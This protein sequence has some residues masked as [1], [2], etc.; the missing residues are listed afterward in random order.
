MY[1]EGLILVV[2]MLAVYHVLLLQ[3]QWHTQSLVILTFC[4][5]AIYG[6]RFYLVIILVASCVLAPLLGRSRPEEGQDTLGTGVR[7]IVIV[8]CFIL[9]LFVLGLTDRM[10]RLIPGDV[11]E[12]LARME[13]SRADLARAESGYLREETISTPQ[14]ALIYFPQGLPYFLTVPWPW[15]LGSF[16]Q[17]IVVP[18]TGG[19]HW[20][21]LLKSSA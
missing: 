1:K 10:Q 11:S 13:S 7:Q 3:K 8:C 4:L 2:L 6:L 20:P 18:D 5:F 16:R 17:N 14:Q 12:S 19:C 15:Q 21:T 9:G